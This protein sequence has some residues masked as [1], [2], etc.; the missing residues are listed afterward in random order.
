L[1]SKLQPLE[2]FKSLPTKDSGSNLNSSK[3][4]LGMMNGC[5]SG[6]MAR[7]STKDNL[8]SVLQDNPK[9]VAHQIIPG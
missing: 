2:P 3:S 6:L 7:M 5:N 9:F 4:T 1:V 8:D